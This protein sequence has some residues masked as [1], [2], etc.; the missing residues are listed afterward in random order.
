VV[1]N[2]LHFNHTAGAYVGRL[3]VLLIGTVVSMQSAMACEGRLLIS[4]KWEN[5]CF[6]GRQDMA[7]SLE[8]CR[9]KNGPPID[10][11]VVPFQIAGDKVDPRVTGVFQNHFN[12]QIAVEGKTGGAQICAPAGITWTAFQ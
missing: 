11:K 4:G 1:V 2:L 8:K 12:V 7:V 3:I 9:F 5:Q 6:V 10:V